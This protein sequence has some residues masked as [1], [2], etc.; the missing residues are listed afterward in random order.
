MMTKLTL[1]QLK[2]DSRYSKTVSPWY[3]DYL[4]KLTVSSSG[5]WWNDNKEEFSHSERESKIN[6]IS[7]MRR[8]CDKENILENKKY[9]TRHDWSV[10]NIYC[11][12]IEDVEAFLTDWGDYVKTIHAPINEK[13][14]KS[15]LENTNSVVRAQLFYKKYRYRIKSWK[16]RSDMDIWTEMAEFIYDN[17]DSDSYHMNNLLRESKKNLELYNKIA[18]KSGFVS[19]LG[20]I[21]RYVP[22]SGDATVYFKNYDDMVTFRMTFMSDITD[23]VKVVT[24]DELG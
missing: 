6:L 15:L 3:K 17:F 11:K 5:I 18:G 24:T 21:H 23:V 22:Y 20:R 9:R 16:R 4:Y 8:W 1:E 10:F 14:E 19:A 12:N 2:T 13:H 7:N